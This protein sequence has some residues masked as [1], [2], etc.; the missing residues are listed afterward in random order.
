MM[1]T[2]CAALCPLEAPGQSACVSV[3]PHP[4]LCSIASRTRMA[5]LLGPKSLCLGWVLNSSSGV[6]HG[7]ETRDGLHCSHASFLPL[8]CV[9][10]RQHRPIAKGCLEGKLM[11]G[12]LMVQQ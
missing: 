9:W 5:G 1:R 6:L 3:E 2:A 10:T 12:D 11:R 8:P 7:T 4:K